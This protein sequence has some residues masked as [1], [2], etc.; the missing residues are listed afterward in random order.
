MSLRGGVSIV[1]TA[2]S[3]D[4]RSGDPFNLA[5]KEG[6]PREN[7]MRQGTNVVPPPSHRREFEWIKARMLDEAAF[8]ADPRF[9]HRNLL[10]VVGAIE[11]NNSVYMVM[12]RLSHSLAKQVETQGPQSQDTIWS[13]L[14]PILD[15]LTQLEQHHC[16]HLDLSPH[17]IMFANDGRPILIDF[18][19]SRL[20]TKPKS[21]SSKLALTDG[22]SAPEKYEFSSRDLD[23][24][25]DVYSLAAVIN[26]ALTGIDPQDRYKRMASPSSNGLDSW[27]AMFRKKYTRFDFLDVV[28]QAF[29]YSKTKR[30]PTVSA[31]GDD[32]AKTVLRSN[33]HSEQ[34]IERTPHYRE[35]PTVNGLKRAVG[36]PRNSRKVRNNRIVISILL[37]LICF[38]LL[39]I[40]LLTI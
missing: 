35:K 28:D 5:I 18:G 25:A 20:P 27:A 36:I 19:F 26:F 13:W 23:A 39:I 24:R 37:L 9:G 2:R 4:A 11:A 21:R 16:H 12:E 1:Y 14:K 30:Y 34:P 33:N 7:G 17:N 32:L 10:Q 15:A 6:K 29:S 22:Y 8:L 31:F 38:L 40:L 3:I